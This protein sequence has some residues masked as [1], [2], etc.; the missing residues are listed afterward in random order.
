LSDPHR[1]KHAELWKNIWNTRCNGTKLLFQEAKNVIEKD[2]MSI[3]TIELCESTLSLA[4]SDFGEA[5]REAVKR[6]IPVY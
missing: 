5:R 4:I 2:P 6:G 1:K 3:S